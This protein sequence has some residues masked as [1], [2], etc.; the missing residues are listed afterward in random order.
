[1]KRLYLS[2]PH[3]TGDERDFVGT[4]I[5]SNWI[6]PLGPH[7][8]AFEAELAAAV[9][10]RAAAAL[11]SGTAALHLALR[12]AG[13]G[14]GDEVLVSTLTFAASVYPAD[15]DAV[16]RTRAFLENEIGAA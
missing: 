12:L 15:A 8:D 3:L 10:V 7:V 14:S 1:M 4:A 11:S 9:G 6:A 5:D 16:G 13:V 2:P